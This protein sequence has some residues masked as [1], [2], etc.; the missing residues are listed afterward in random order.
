MTVAV[1]ES[2]RHAWLNVQSLILGFVVSLTLKGVMDAAY[3]E[4]MVSVATWQDLWR[5]FWHPSSI[6]FVVFLLTLVRFVYGAYRVVE[7]CDDTSGGIE[8]WNIPGLLGLFVLFY[9]TG[10]AVRHTEPFYVAL[11][12]VHA[13]DLGWFIMPSIFSDR[14]RQRMRT[15]V[16]S[17]LVFDVLTIGALLLPLFFARGY[18]EIIAPTFMVLVGV[19]DFWWNRAF[20][21]YPS[22][23]KAHT[24]ERAG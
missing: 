12:A 9:I 5:V 10:L 4:A 14:L 24:P 11:A 15:V 3:G 16:R 6:Q 18:F 17:F 7:E 13:W 2:N 21:F 23:W 8:I 22:Q 20:F 1:P 19:A